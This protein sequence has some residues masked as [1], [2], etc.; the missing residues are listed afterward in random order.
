MMQE[1][2]GG[3]SFVLWGLPFVLIGIFFIVGRF[4]LG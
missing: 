3:F 4:F 1:G 2:G